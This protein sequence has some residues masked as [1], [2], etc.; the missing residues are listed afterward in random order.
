MSAKVPFLKLPDSRD[1]IAS[2]GLP[3]YN[4]SNYIG[5][6]IESILEQDFGDF[7]LI[8][9][10]NASTDDTAAI[11][12]K[13]AVM[14]RRIT[15]MRQPE[16]LGAARNYNDVFRA[17]SGTY[18]KWAAH[19]DLLEPQFLSRCIEGF[20]RH[21][22]LP[23]I[24]YP[25][26]EFIDADGKVLRADRSRHSMHTVSPFPAVRVF[27]AIQ[28]MSMVT[29]VFG[30]F[31]RETLARTRL[32]DS[33]IASD[34][35]LLLECAL[36]GHIVHLESEPLFQRRIHENMSRQANRTDEEVLKWFDPA[37]R[38]GGSS[39]RRLF[40]EYMKSIY[41]IEGLSVLQRQSC[42]TSL[43]G[44]I[45]TRRARVAAGRWR[46]QVRAVGGNGEA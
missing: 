37:A 26:S 21:E 27:R 45:L 38:A 32:I 17:A 31:H 13:Y 28:A 2:I 16:N 23:A 10:D 29:A 35:V 30:L 24:V 7:E 9:S 11:C 4:G 40:Q 5:Q 22:P 18:F 43:V 19:D 8:I 46:R 41:H 34:Y 42:A 39:K 12:E 36:L 3:V 20:N 25:R 14:D 6:A 33:F 44:S 1:P 15:Y